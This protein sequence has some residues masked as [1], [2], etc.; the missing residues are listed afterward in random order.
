VNNESNFQSIMG[1]L[2]RIETKI[3]D[4][5]VFLIKVTETNSRSVEEHSGVLKDLVTSID[6]HTKV[7]TQT[8]NKLVSIVTD[9]QTIPMA[10][11]KWMAKVWGLTVVVLL[12]IISLLVVGYSFVGLKLPGVEHLYQENMRNQENG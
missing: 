3:T 4:V 10:S 12:A 9:G 7:L 1:Q 2:S 5:E 8:F 6:G 11:H